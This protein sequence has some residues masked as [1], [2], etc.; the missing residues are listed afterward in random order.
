MSNKI[1][2]IVVTKFK[3]VVLFSEDN[4]CLFIQEPSR[5]GNI[6]DYL[7]KNNDLKFDYLMCLS[8]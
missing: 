4:N 5:W 3:D 8:G 2:D 6:S 1:I 7:F